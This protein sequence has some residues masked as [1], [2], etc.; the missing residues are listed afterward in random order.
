MD[1]KPPSSDASSGSCLMVSQSLGSSSQVR[2]P[3]REARMGAL[4]SGPSC[5]MTRSLEPTLSSRCFEL[6]RKKTQRERPR[7]YG[8][9]LT[10]TRRSGLRQPVPPRPRG[11]RHSPSSWNNSPLG[12]HRRAG[13][14]RKKEIV[15][16]GI[17]KSEKIPRCCS[18]H[19]RA[20]SVWRRAGCR[21][22]PERI[23]AQPA[24]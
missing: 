23:D 3:E 22:M 17:P 1:A 7:L 19:L 15:S 6:L 2:S 8:R 18:L 13:L 11:A 4:L 5:R 10:R 21:Q 12:N 20:R 14:S 16:G 9:V 24:A